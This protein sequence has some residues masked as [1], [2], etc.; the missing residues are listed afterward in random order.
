MSPDSVTVG[1]DPPNADPFNVRFDI[2]HVDGTV[3][4]ETDTELSVIATEYG[5]LAV[6]VSVDVMP[7]ARLVTLPEIPKFVA[8]VS[9]APGVGCVDLLGSTTP[10]I[11]PM[12]TSTTKTPVN[13]ATRTRDRCTWRS[14][15]AISAMRP[16]QRTT[17]AACMR[18][19]SPTVE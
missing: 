5:L 17:C 9:R 8:D 1:G 16:F 10:N 12:T 4:T 18:A 3:G 19:Q 13:S 14:G 2:G 6:S 11:R 7:G 15:G